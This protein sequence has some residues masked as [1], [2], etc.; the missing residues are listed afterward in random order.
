MSDEEEIWKTY[1][2]Y[3]F[4]EVS[5][6]G[7]VRTKDRVVTYKNGASHFYKGHILKQHLNNRGYLCVKIYLGGEQIH[8]LAHRMVAIIYVPNPD[9]LPEVNH[10]DN[11]RANNNASNLEWCTSQYNQDYRKNFGTSASELLGKP[12]IAVNPKTSEVFLF[13]TQSEAGRRLGVRQG[14]ISM[15]V[16]GKRY[17]KTAGGC[18][19][20]RADK[21]SIEKARGKF[22]DDIAEKVKKLMQET[23]K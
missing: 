20:C 16:K 2:D 18:W 19:F 13:E 3:D 17:H 9:N 10:K 8:L 15:V 14:D 6:L 21:N 7:R 1:P 11:N 22:G 12:V 23:Q 4:I 5:N